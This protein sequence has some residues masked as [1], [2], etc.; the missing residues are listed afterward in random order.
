MHKH[1]TTAATKTEMYQK[2]NTF[3]QTYGAILTQQNRPDTFKHTFVHKMKDLHE[4][5]SA[6]THKALIHS[7]ILDI[8]SQQRT[9]MIQFESCLDEFN[10]Y[11]A[12]LR[13]LDTFIHHSI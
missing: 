4:D 5:I 11:L 10:T 2:I 6:G 7:S 8:L 9:F 12:A 1:P 3:W 13:L